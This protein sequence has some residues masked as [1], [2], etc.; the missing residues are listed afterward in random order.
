MDLSSTFIILPAIFLIGKLD[1]EDPFTIN[2]A[3]GLY[4]TVHVIV[5]VIV[6]LMHKKISASTDESK[7]TIERP[8]EPG[9]TIAP[10]DKMETLTVKEFQ[11]RVLKKQGTPE[12]RANARPR[13]LC[14]E[15][16]RT[17]ARPGPNF[18]CTPAAPADVP[19]SCPYN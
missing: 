13:S 1:K 16:A 18:C 14:A 12:K 2:C 6:Y 15:P 4:A 9:K 10:E 5:F 17:W 7:I 11:Q 8:A 19:V 3:R